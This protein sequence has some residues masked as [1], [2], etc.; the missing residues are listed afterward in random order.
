LLPG[1]TA[2]VLV[3]GESVGVLGQVHPRIAAGLD[4]TGDVFLFELDVPE[5]LEKL[6]GRVAHRP[7]SRFPSVIQDLALVVDAAVPAAR[8]AAIIASTALVADVRLFD[9]YEGSSLPAGKRS[10][11]FQ[12][13]FQAQDRT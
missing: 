2:S 6:P 4:L 9:V 3:K 13:Q 10:L 11:A 7:L 12:V 1:V 5:L 8:L